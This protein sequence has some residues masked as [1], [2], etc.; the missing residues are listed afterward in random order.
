MELSPYGVRRL[1]AAFSPI[2]VQVAGPV[3]IA[4]RIIIGAVQNG[5]GGAESVSR[6]GAGAL[7]GSGALRYRPKI[8]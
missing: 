7:D 4:S 1:D 2:N 3:L 6:E 8:K 5:L